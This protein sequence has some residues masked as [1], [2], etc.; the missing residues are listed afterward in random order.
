MPESSV[1]A[2][3]QVSE[4]AQGYFLESGAL[5]FDSWPWKDFW[6]ATRCDN[7]YA[8]KAVSISP[9]ADLEFDLMDGVDGNWLF[10]TNEDVRF[11]SVSCM[12]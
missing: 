10:S 3:Q 12:M 1:F 6:S 4:A 9:K 7:Y 5:I 11:D 8:F 2:G